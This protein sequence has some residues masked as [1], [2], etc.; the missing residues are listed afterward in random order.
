MDEHEK[1][2]V[3]LSLLEQISRVFTEKINKERNLTTTHSD[4]SYLLGWIE[5]KKA[6]LGAIAEC[7]NKL[8]AI[9]KVPKP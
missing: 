6:I 9:K 5:A 7:N 8:A 2:E 4:S 3:Q 1:L